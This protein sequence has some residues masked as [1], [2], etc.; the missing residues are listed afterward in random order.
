MKRECGELWRRYKLHGD[1]S[2]REALILAYTP[3][4]K[5]VV[6]RMN[7]TPM[8]YLDRDDLLTH[9][10]IGLIDA[11]DKCDLE[12][13]RQFEAYARAR[14][15]GA[16]IDGIRE[17]DWVPRVTRRTANQVENM[18]AQL[19]ATLGR[20]A[21][22][23]E[24]AEALDLDPERLRSITAGVDRSVMLSLDDP[25]PS[26]DGESVALADAIP[27]PNSQDPA[28]RVDA[29]AQQEALA[30][31][32]RQLEP[33]E[34]LVVTLYYYEDLTLREIGEVLGRTEARVCQIHKAAIRKI[35]ARLLDAQEVFLAA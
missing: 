16:V 15:R 4:V 18:R 29:L 6:D 23:D 8:A 24:L 26:G 34:R 22:T 27:N 32:I 7:I 9:A 19:S 35:Q 3:L 5:H 31:A 21:T 14:V 12:R 30:D 28:T 10:I 1:A 33:D 13:W 17:M 2:A 11:I 25:I 20:S